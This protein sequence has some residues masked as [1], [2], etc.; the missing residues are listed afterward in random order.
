MPAQV[1]NLLAN[2]SGQCWTA[3]CSLLIIPIYIRLLGLEQYGLISIFLVFQACL[4]LLDLGLSQTLTREISTLTPSR[5]PLIRHIFRT[6]E[7]SVYFLSLAIFLLSIAASGPLSAT[8]SS[9]S[10]GL[11]AT[12]L[13]Y[14]ISLMGL[15]LSFKLVESTYRSVLVGSR[16]HILLN[17]IQVIRTTAATFGSLLAFQFFGASIIT[18]LAWQIFISIVTL[19][20]LAIFAYSFLKLTSSPASFRPLLLL[21][22][23]TTPLE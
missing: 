3:I 19:S 20:I 2:Y 7:I 22:L 15:T 13:A 1:K 9:N 23:K 11:D 6:I 10:N 18:Y 5:T 4:P 17:S 16:Q 12:F 21:R 14:V 8:L